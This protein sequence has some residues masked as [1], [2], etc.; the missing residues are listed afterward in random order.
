[1]N[2]LEW[3]DALSLDLPEMDDTHR[4]FVALLAAVQEAPDAQLAA[5]WRALIEHTESHFGQEDRW[6]QDTR[7]ASGNCHA[8]Q[9]FVVLKVMR[10]GEDAAQAGRPDVI[11]LMAH[12][13][14]AWFPQHAQ[15]MDAA[16]ALHLRRVGYNLATGLVS[17]P[18]ALPVEKIRGCAGAS[19][20]TVAQLPE[21][22]PV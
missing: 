12:E 21:P 19:C 1:M 18:Q 17:L 8:T 7:F 3:S 20:S 9:H 11:R 22:A 14:A 16:L 6:M 5:A 10:E 2:R 15:S 4:E 13:L